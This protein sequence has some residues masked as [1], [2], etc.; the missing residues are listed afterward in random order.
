V[1]TE[2][3]LQSWQLASV[4]LRALQQKK[5][6]YCCHQ[7]QRNLLVIGGGPSSE[8]A[9]SVLAVCLSATELQDVF[10]QQSSL[11]RPGTTL[12]ALLYHSVP[13]AVAMLAELMLYSNKIDSFGHYLPIMGIVAHN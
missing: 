7:S 2:S 6:S 8:A 4:R 10:T 5:T 1:S 13:R 9:E 11:S 3:A 12:L